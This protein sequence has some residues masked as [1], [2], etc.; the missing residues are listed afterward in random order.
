M[1]M[2]IVGMTMRANRFDMVCCHALAQAEKGQRSVSVNPLD[3]Q[4][5][6]LESFRFATTAVIGTALHLAPTQKSW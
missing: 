3:K 4:G 1:I 5:R 6:R 2:K